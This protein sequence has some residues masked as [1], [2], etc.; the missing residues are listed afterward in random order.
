MNTFSAT[1]D[2]YFSFPYLLTGASCSSLRLSLVTPDEWENISLFYWI[3][4][5]LIAQTE[6][7]NL[8]SGL[9]KI[10]LD[11][12]SNKNTTRFVYALGL[13][14]HNFLNYQK[15]SHLCYTRTL[16][17]PSS[18]IFVGWSVSLCFQNDYT[19]NYYCTEKYI[20]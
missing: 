8:W 3:I 9:S 10:N 7:V 1:L 11:R 17:F 14:P 20:N 18:L 5:L 15:I 2:L 6:G 19:E 13:Y 4:I 12:S 16:I